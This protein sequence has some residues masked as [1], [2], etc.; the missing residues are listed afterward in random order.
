MTKK[1]RAAGLLLVVCMLLCFSGCSFDI[2]E[3]AYRNVFEPYDPLEEELS[4]EAE[5]LRQREAEQEAITRNPVDDLDEAFEIILSECSGDFIGNHP[6]DETFLAWMYARYGEQMIEEIATAVK[7]E[8]EDPSIWYHLTGC[9]IQVLWS[10]FQRDSGFQTDELENV[11]W[12]EAA[13]EKEIV[14]DFS[15]DVNFTDGL[16]NMIHL[17]ES[18]NGIG[19]CFSEELIAEMKSADI[20]MINNEFTYSTRGE[21]LKGKPFTFRADPSTVALLEDLGVDIVGIANNH[22]YD[23]GP[24]ALVDTVDTLDGAGMPH[25]GA[26][27]NLSEAKEPCYFILNG[28][29]IGIVAATQIERSLNYTKEATEDTPGVLKTLNPDK[30]IGVIEETKRNSDIVVVFVH[31]GTEGNSAY[32]AD[33]AELAREFVN[34]GADVIIG[35]HTHCLQG[36]TY[37]DDTPVIY[38][39]GNY[40]FSST[41]TDGKRTAETGLAQVR[42]DAEGRIK[43]RFLPCMQEDWKTRLLTNEGEA[44]RV[45]AYEESLSSGVT[46]ENDGFVRKAK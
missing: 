20:C 16:G 4:I 11:Y 44:S 46:I 31:W 28:R 40:W 23:Y 10:E 21:P 7:N 24:D 45:I 3:L 22:V 2:G 6:I 38:S 12:K 1:K 5:L 26:G 17:R 30:F 41:P 19:D 8:Y 15:G 13:S 27:K 9:T 32:G 29:K 42:I 18:A 39:L 37:I 14:M 43:F 33:Q 25:V 35:G 34:A 36:I